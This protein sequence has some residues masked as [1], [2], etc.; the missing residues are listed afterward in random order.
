MS[1]DRLFT[2]YVQ[3][4]IAQYWIYERHDGTCVLVSQFENATRFVFRFA[5][6]R[7]EKKIQLAAKRL[8]VQVL[9]RV[10]YD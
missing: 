10:Q 7:A 6:E 2:V 4:A 1:R 9:T 8:G 5:A 3:T